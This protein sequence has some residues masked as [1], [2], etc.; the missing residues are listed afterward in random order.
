MYREAV[1]NTLRDDRSEAAPSLLRM[2]RRAILDVDKVTSPLELA[3]ISRFLE[4]S[5]SG[6]LDTTNQLTFG[7]W[8]AGQAI[9][10]LGATLRDQSQSALH[11]EIR[12]SLE[13]FLKDTPDTSLIPRTVNALEPE[14]YALYSNVK[15]GYWTYFKGA[16]PRTRN[17]SYA[18][19]VH[20][21]SCDVLKL[22]GRPVPS[23][24][25]DPRVAE[26]LRAGKIV[27]AL[28]RG[29]E[30]Y[31]SD[32][33]YFDGRPGSNRREVGKIKNRCRFIVI[34]DSSDN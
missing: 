2:S 33:R 15:V 20:K 29:S 14:S 1:F 28:E 6:F 12:S 5:K 21:F 9:R 17:R 24:E 27:Q 7:N 22:T 10:V 30:P 34:P 11:K 16:L 18:R 31:H 13:K 3:D 23:I 32:E 26:C 8:M 25:G 19:F 4:T